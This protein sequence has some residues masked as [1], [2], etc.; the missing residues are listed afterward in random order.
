MGL[1]STRKTGAARSNGATTMIRRRDQRSMKTPTNGPIS[2]NGTITIA[3]A[4]AKLAAVVERSGEND[5]RGD[6]RGLHE[7]VGGLAHEAHREQPPEVGVA[8]RVART[9]QR[10]G[11]SVGSSGPW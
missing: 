8:Q 10:R 1:A 2:E 4:S 7:S 5:E 11:G 6:E 3:D 9:P